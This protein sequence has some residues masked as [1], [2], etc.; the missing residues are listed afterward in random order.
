LLARAQISAAG[1]LR[2]ARAVASYL[3]DSLDQLNQHVRAYWEQE[4][5]GTDLR[6]VGDAQPLSREWFDR[7]ERFRYAREPYI[8]AAAQFTRWAG[9]DVLEIGV[10]AGTDHLQF[11]RAGARVV[12]VDLTDMAIETTRHHLGLYGTSSD[13]HR[14]DAEKL[15]FD[16]ESF[17]LVYSWGVI[18]HA[19]F[20]QRVI[21]EVQ[22]VLRP[23]GE[24]VGMFY[25]RHSLL[26]LR[27][28]IAH[29]LRTGKPWRSFADVVWHNMESIGTK[30]YTEAELRGLFKG[31]A[32]CGTT[33][34]VTPYDLDR[35]PTWLGNLLP[36]KVGW[37][38][39]VH[40]S[41]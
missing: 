34:V 23:G 6:I 22:R 17:D 3:V 35:L 12:G 1:R 10:G 40:A 31:F 29:A 15:P 21:D 13:L 41:A 11:A 16:A 36:P 8:H 26:V 38:I 14:V 19:A 9:R 2:E 20:P 27:M 4:A 24:F 28:W 32:S 33:P 7:V 39:I 37:N 18:H 5:C 30:A 25:A